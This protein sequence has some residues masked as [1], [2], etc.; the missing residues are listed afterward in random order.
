MKS[1]LQ[2]RIVKIGVI[3]G[4]CALPVWMWGRATAQYKQCISNLTL[5]DQI[6]QSWFIDGRKALNESPT[7][8]EIFGETRFIR[9]KPV[10]PLGGEY[11][12]GSVI[13]PPTCTHPGHA[14]RIDTNY[15][16]DPRRYIVD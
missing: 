16:K 7:D 8:A 11:K 14:I 15:F 5:M 10:C 12:F 9:A 1:L 4:L 2:K 13:E 6:T 3:V